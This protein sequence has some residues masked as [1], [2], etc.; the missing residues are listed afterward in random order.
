MP[1]LLTE[2]SIGP[3]RVYSN[4]HPIVQKRS[5]SVVMHGETVSEVG[6]WENPVTSG[7]DRV[8]ANPPKEWL[9]LR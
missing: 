5:A 4:K 9:Q 8:L 1:H 7:L 2:Y 3:A 6:G